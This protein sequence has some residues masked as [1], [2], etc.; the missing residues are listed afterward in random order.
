MAESMMGLKR[1]HRC[2]EVST[3]NIGQEVTVMG[4]VAKSRNKGGH[5]FC[6]PQGPFRNPSGHF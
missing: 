3:A 2:T 4:W 6:G 5:Y 1:S